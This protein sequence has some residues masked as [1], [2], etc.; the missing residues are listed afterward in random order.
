MVATTCFPSGF[1]RKSD[2]GDKYVARLPSKYARVHFKTP[3]P[4][5]EFRKAQTRSRYARAC[6]LRMLSH[7]PVVS[8]CERDGEVSTSS[9]LLPS[10][11]D[12]RVKLRWLCSPVVGI[13][14]VP[15]LSF[16]VWE[17]RRQS[18]AGDDTGSQQAYA[19]LGR[20]ARR[21][22]IIRRGA[23][24]SDGQEGG[25]RI[26]WRILKLELEERRQ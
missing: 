18:N 7:S 14:T 3:L 4:P 16:Y 20:P 17:I 21:P 24:D 13:T 9:L 12:R 11:L 19:S 10:K 2:I 25:R 26:L 23:H 8:A 22:V 15:F 5:G 6:S 1:P